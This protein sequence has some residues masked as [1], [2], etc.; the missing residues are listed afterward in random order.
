MKLREQ[1]GNIENI[2]IPMPLKTNHPWHWGLDI[3]SGSGGRKPAQV[4]GHYGLSQATQDL[5]ASLESNPSPDQCQVKEV[6]KGEA[7]ICMY[8]SP[9][10]QETRPPEWPITP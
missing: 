10:C 1:V 9:I 3:L 6:T 5:K 2:N 4:R 8:Y 7:E